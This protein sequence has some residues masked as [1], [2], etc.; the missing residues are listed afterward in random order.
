[1]L[2]VSLIGQPSFAPMAQAQS[3]DS[4]TSRQVLRNSGGEPAAAASD[5][6]GAAPA[7]RATSAE[8]KKGDPAPQGVES[9]EMRT[10]TVTARR[11][12][13]QIDRSVFD[14]QSEVITP[15]ASV[16]DVIANVPNVSVDLD[17][18]VSIRGNQN[19]Q[20]F[21]DGKPSAM[22]SGP[23]AGNALNSY[24]AAAL[25]SVEVITTPGAEFGSQ[26]GGGPILNLVTRR[27]RPPAAHGVVSINVG[28]EGRGGSMLSGSYVTGRAQ[29]EGVV[30]L[31]RN[32]FDR[33]G[34]S[35]SSRDDGISVWKT[36][37]EYTSHSPST[38]LAVS[39]TFRYNLGETNRLTAALNFSRTRFGG[40]S[41]GHYR[42]YLDGIIPYE[43][44]TRHSDSH[45]EYTS[46]Q[47]ALG[48]ERKFSASEELKVDL[49]NSGSDSDN[50]NRNRDSYLIAP[51][52]GLRPDSIYGNDTTSRLTELSADYTKRIS[53]A[54]NAKLGAKLGWSRGRTDADFFN[55]DPLTGEEVFDQARNS[56]FNSTERS[57]ALYFAPNLRISEHW[58]LDPG[59]RYEEVRRQIDYLNQVK[60]VQDSTS[61]MLPSLHLQYG[62]G[63]RGAAVT[64]AYSRRITR[65]SPGDLYPSL[66]YVNEQN[67]NQGDPRL[68]PTH[69]DKYEIKYTD[70]WS[71]VN[72]NLSL[73]RENDS[74]LLGR[75]YVAVP[76]SVT[77]INKAVNFGAKSNG[78]I[79]WNLQV[80][81]SRDWQLDATASFRRMT[82]IF[83]ASLETEHK[84][85]S[86]NLQLRAQ[87]H[88]FKDHTMQLD[89]NY[90]GRQLLGLSESEPNWQANASWSWRLAPKLTL[91]SSIRDIFDSYRA[92]NTLITGTVRQYNYSRQQGR[93]LTV[94]FS[95]IFGGVSGDAQLRNKVTS[96][97][98][99]AR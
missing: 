49:R 23:N 91:R 24:P 66:Q 26:G 16:A 97:P 56:G 85:A 14:V 76:D 10:V 90:S 15:N 30:S 59:L 38:M 51:P 29:L 3:Q 46:Y 6:K 2:L 54:L 18:K 12:T 48:W 61:S 81:P 19:V 33:Q 5:A 34:S 77:L 53:S 84:V 78:G 87:Y 27:E 9:R 20:V 13:E 86:R 1:M 68:A 25:K 35:V 45:S 88:G 71:W 98:V 28:A 79:S 36:Q 39:P 99:Q 43:A 40:N 96:A 65:P 11:A 93:I 74:P 63:E 89:G 94:A 72:S 60:L 75:V 73:F 31:M 8:Q 7:V 55:I 95:Y 50:S 17:G 92:R 22:F 4:A 47:A 42:T 58:R 83:L 67:Y 37:R 69:N 64:G 52:A 41:E 21:V 57:Y 62:W 44:Y 32:V 70:S 80:K 82:Q